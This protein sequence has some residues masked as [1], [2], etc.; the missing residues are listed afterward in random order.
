M[1]NFSYLNCSLVEL[2]KHTQLSPCGASV[3]A[4]AAIAILSLT[5]IPTEALLAA[6]AL[7]VTTV[8]LLATIST[9]VVFFE[10]LDELVALLDL[11]V[12]ALTVSTVGAVNS[13]ALVLLLELVDEE[14]TSLLA[15]F[16][17]LILL[18]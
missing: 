8:A 17:P 18:E 4:L 16:A 3:S 15:V 11:F 5:L 1:R 12:L 10:I 6:E 9:F 14:V 13:L 2:I 7:L